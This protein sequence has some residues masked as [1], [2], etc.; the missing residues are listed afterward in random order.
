MGS[1]SITK[2][3]CQYVKTVIEI[4]FEYQIFIYAYFLSWENFKRVLIHFNI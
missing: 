1:K 2:T 4:V 3:W